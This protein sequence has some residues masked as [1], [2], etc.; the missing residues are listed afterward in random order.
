MGVR[1]QGRRE[2]Q[3]TETARLDHVKRRRRRP[4]DFDV[5]LRLEPLEE[6]VLL[7]VNP[8][9][10]PNWQEQGPSTIFGGGSLIPGPNAATPFDDNPASGAVQAI[11]VHPDA[12]H[13]FLGTVNGGIWRTTIWNRRETRLFNQGK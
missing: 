2:S 9:S 6:R 10:I 12:T 11:A 5:R 3:G 8:V 13:V 7:A 4:K 1:T